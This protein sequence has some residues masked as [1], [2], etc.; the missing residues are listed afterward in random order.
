MRLCSL[1][2]SPILVCIVD[3]ERAGLFRERNEL[4]AAKRSPI[5]LSH[6]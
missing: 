4:G 2:I 1:V 5:H 6:V 3:L